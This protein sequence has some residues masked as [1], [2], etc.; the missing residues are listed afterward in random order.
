MN[1]LAIAIVIGLVTLSALFSGLTLGLMSLSPHAL[2]RKMRLGDKDAAKI[3]PIRQK[4]T[5]LLSTLLLGNVAVNAVLSVFLGSLTAG[6]IAVIAATVLIVILGEILPQAIISRHALTFGARTTW[7]VRA[8][9][10]LLY[11]FTKPISMALDRMLGEELPAAFSKRE[12]ALLLDEQHKHTGSDLGGE[13]QL[14]AQSL[15]FADRQVRDIMTR[16]KDVYAVGAS[17]RFTQEFLNALQEQGHSR[18]PVVDPRTQDVVG[19]LYAKDLVAATADPKLTA[20]D[21]MRLKVTT[22]QEDAKLGSILALFK[23]RK[24]HLFVVRDTLYD[25]V[26][27]VTLEDVI[28]EITGEIEDEH[29]EQ[30]I[31]NARA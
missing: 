17:Q 7:L 27:I 3:Y 1:L 14:A 16:W 12:I 21:V 19:I 22:V 29:D 25:I 20:V 28:E 8:F 6:V 31:L 11:P 30:I 2:R 18:I 24:Q 15:A 9:I 26:G 23:R 4:G 13:A 5:L 10:Y